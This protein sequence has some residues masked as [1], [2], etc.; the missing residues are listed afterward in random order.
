M[1]ITDAELIIPA[2]ADA[3][4]AV[5]AGVPSMAPSMAPAAAPASVSA[6]APSMAPA[7]PA[8]TAA[9][10]PAAINVRRLTAFGAD[11]TWVAALAVPSPRGWRYH[12][13]IGSAMF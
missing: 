9:T 2:E 11:R 13:G 1:S 12:T 6:V 4:G 7:A 3:P 8:S 5:P 10:P